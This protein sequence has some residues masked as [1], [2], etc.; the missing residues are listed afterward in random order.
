[1]IT[2]PKMPSPL[3]GVLVDMA[4]ASPT[5]LLK[6]PSHQMNP[7]GAMAAASEVD[8]DDQ[9]EQTAELALKEKREKLAKDKLGI[10]PEMDSSV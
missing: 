2:G 3:G 9:P 8:S 4:K 1:M 6:Q 10:Q 5:G 7:N